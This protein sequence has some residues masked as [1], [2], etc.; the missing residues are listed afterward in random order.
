[1]ESAHKPAVPTCVC[2]G[3]IV[4]NPIWLLVVALFI[5]LPTIMRRLLCLANPAVPPASMW[6]HLSVCSA[7]EHLI[8]QSHRCWGS[9][10]LINSVSWVFNSCF[11]NSASSCTCLWSDPTSRKSVYLLWNLMGVS[12]FMQHRIRG[13][14]TGHILALIHKHSCRFFTCTR[15]GLMVTNPSAQLLLRMQ[16]ILAF[17]NATAHKM[18]H[19]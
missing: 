13:C 17:R 7:S 9:V 10:P 11:A 16:H 15:V 19:K 14:F 5:P 8:A 4:L 1:M 18:K 2:R 12:Q 6:C 3:L